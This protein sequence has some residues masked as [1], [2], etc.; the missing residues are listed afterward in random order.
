MRQR[1]ERNPFAAKLHADLYITF[2]LR[3]IFMLLN[4]LKFLY[5]R[6]LNILDYRA[7]D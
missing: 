5:L 6:C 4:C 1:N 3:Y 7:C 2:V